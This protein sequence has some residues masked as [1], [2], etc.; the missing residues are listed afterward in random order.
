MTTVDQ[1]FTEVGSFSTYFKEGLKSIKEKLEGDRKYLQEA[2]DEAFAAIEEIVSLV[3][4]IAKVSPLSLEDI[5]IGEKFYGA[6]RVAD[7]YYIFTIDG[8][9]Y[10]TVSSDLTGNPRVV[11]SQGQLKDLLT[12]WSCDRVMRLTLGVT[13]H[14][15]QW[16]VNAIIDERTM[17]DTVKRNQENI[18]DNLISLFQKLP[19]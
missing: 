11:T 16:I 12:D 7:T 6:L 10:Y 5:K 15:L 8:K 17:V 4:A 9:E 18:R 13:E 1:Q 2:R 3:F 14:F 19:A